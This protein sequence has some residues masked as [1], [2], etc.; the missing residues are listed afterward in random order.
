MLTP[1]R[2]RAPNQFFG[3]SGSNLIRSSRFPR[4]MAGTGRVRPSPRSAPRRAG[5]FAG[6]SSG[7]MLTCR[8]AP[9]Q[10]LLPQ[11]AEGVLGEPLLEIGRVRPGEHRGAFL[12]L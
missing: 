7:H 11:L 9:D 3:S 4:D 10:I 5:E 1:P 8:S 2:R 12:P 6:T